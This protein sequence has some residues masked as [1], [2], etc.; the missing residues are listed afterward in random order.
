MVQRVTYSILDRPDGRFELVVFRGSGELFARRVFRTLAQA[1]D[2]VDWL[3][4]L[5]T[6][7]G[8]PVVHAPGMTLVSSA[9]NV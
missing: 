6:V 1:D 2:E 5:M 9:P 4:V 7:C 8:A 3:R